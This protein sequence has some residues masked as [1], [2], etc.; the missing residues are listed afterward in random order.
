MNDMIDDDNLLDD[1][2]YTVHE[3]FNAKKLVDSVKAYD[4]N[5]F[6]PIDNADTDADGNDSI[7]HTDEDDDS[8]SEDEEYVDDDWD[9]GS[10]ILDKSTMGAIKRNDNLFYWEIDGLLK[11]NGKQYSFT[12]LQSNPPKLVFKRPGMEPFTVYLGKKEVEQ[13]APAL[14]RVRRA[15]NAVPI[16]DPKKEHITKKNWRRKLRESFEDNPIGFIGKIVGT[17]AVIVIAVFAVLL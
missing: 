10:V 2:K 12:H 11:E 8:S 13:L 4:D 6:T 17:L 9:D 14:E 16:D 1:Y 15:M 5:A 7:E 3:P